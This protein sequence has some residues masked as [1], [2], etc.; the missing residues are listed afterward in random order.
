M[1]L[2]KMWYVLG[3][4]PMPI[5]IARRV[6]NAVLNF[7]WDSKPPKISYNMMIGAVEDG[8]LGLQDPEL[9][10]KS[11]RIKTVKKFINEENDAEWKT[12]MSFYLNKCRNMEIGDYILRMKLKHEMI[13]GISE[14]YEVLEVW[15]ALLPNVYF[16]LERKDDF[17]N[18]PLFLNENILYKGQRTIF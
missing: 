13:K 6:K 14:F 2:A 11:F 8:G 9:K 7:I 16:K 1:I 18:Q 15:K 3:V 4:V 12:A 10:E 17:L 5:W